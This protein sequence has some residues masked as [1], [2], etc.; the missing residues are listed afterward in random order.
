MKKHGRKWLSLLLTGTLVLTFS[1]GCA[2]QKGGVSLDPREPVT[3]NVWH[4][5]NGAQKEAFD[6]L[7]GGA[8]SRVSLDFMNKDEAKAAF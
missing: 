7:Q 8:H 1:A 2:D 5:Y 6:S 3:I 4:Y